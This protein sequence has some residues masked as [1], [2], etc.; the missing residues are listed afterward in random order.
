LKDKSKAVVFML[1]SALA[2]ALM[3]ANVRL[4]GNIPLFEKVFFRNFVS[5]LVAFFIILKTKN[6]ILENVEN[7]KYL[8]ARSLL[9]LLGVVLYFFAINNLFLADSSMLNKLS[10]FFVTFF[11]WLF[12]KEKLSKFQIVALIIAFFSALLII[13]PKLELSILPAFAGFL[14]AMFAG[15]AYTLVRFL[16]SREKPATIVFFFSLISVIGM[17]PLMIMDFKIPTFSQLIFLLGTGIFAAIGQFGLTLAYKFAKASEVAIYNYTNIIFSAI[18]GY[19]LWKEISDT[20]S[21]V[22]GML[23]ISTSIIVYFYS[24]KKK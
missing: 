16:G 11:A 10:P 24:K 12:L 17:F 14:S 18:I 22:G 15:A 1:I 8:L 3:A 21:I 4:A 2:F 9:G 23:L 20:W 13:K 7:L 5:L 19:F 6:K